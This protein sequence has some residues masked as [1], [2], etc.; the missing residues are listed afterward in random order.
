M[1]MSTVL[2]VLPAAAVFGVALSC[3]SA[4]GRAPAA[5]QAAAGP[6]LL[7]VPAD[8]TVS[9]AVSF[10]VGSQDDPKGKE[11]LAYLTASLLAEGG[12]RS[13][14][15]P[16][17]LAALYPLAA[18]YDVR[19]DKEMTTLS[20]RTHGDNLEVYAG[21]F[22]AA[23]LEPRFDPADFERLKASQTTFL[24]KTLR[25][26]SDEE[27]AKA[28]LHGFVFAGT[29][30]A[31][32]PQ[33]TVEGV[34]AITL[35][36]VEAFYRQRFTRDRAVVAVGGGY[37]PG[38]VAQMEAA[39]A[40]LPQ[41]RP[42]ATPAPLPAP[43]AGR[44]LLLVAK[45]GADASISFGFPLDVHRG[46]R[47]FYALWIA[48]SWLG[49]HRSTV[50]HL[51]QVIREA[52][53][54]NYGDYS[55]IEVFPEGGARSM[56][57]HNVPRRR[58]LFEVWIRTLPNENAH[59]ALRAALRELEDLVAGGMSEE[60]FQL[61]RAFLAKYA[62]HF[63]E[64]TAQRLGYALDD[65][66]Y[67]VEGDGHLARFQA[68]MSSLTRDE[69][70]AALKR[71]FEAENLKIAMVTGDAE[72]L[73]QALV[74]EAPSPMTYG[75]EKPAALLAEDKEIEKYPLRINPAKVTVVPIEEF[76]QR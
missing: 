51:Y 49:E 28:A 74:S 11:G 10:A 48:N 43:I 67:G 73:M 58:Q 64:T 75:D 14:S 25:F 76:L 3:A 27:L 70:N 63:A 15:Y 1:T 33:G 36:D 60:E 23:F 13:R 41:G 69:V 42:A 6:V 9:L 39:V 31:H 54:M 66:F 19:V 56:P 40:K 4:G 52:R 17:I 59:F 5:G 29:P 12:T 37:P 44:E 57:P 26:S 71:H 8:P 22:T 47:D 7:A 46:E 65:R 61:S 20:G 16:E 2:S 34:A 68:M 32:P 30:Y 72:G 18:T 50:S 24:E 35:A 21:L 55:Y 45:P 38:L 62:L 53:G